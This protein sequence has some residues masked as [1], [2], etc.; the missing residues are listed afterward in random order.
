MALAA[1]LFS[2]SAVAEAVFPEKVTLAACYYHARAVSGT[3]TLGPKESFEEGTRVVTAKFLD[4]FAAGLKER[5]V[6]VETR[7]CP[8][9]GVAPTEVEFQGVEIVF[10]FLVFPYVWGPERV[11]VGGRVRLGPKMFAS[12]TERGEKLPW[13]HQDDAA[14]VATNVV[15]NALKKL[16]APQVQAVAVN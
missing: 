12:L 8:P 11:A 9:A 4:A 5:G 6:A 2:V 16:A 10:D 7:E 13:L 14:T 1:L 3:K 15:G